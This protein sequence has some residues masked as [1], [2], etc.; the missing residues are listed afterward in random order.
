MNTSRLSFSSPRGSLLIVAM[1]LCGVIGISLVS[2]MHLGRSALTLS[3]RAVYNN[4]AMNLAEQ[5]IEEAMY[6]VNQLVAN[7]AYT[8]PDWTTDATVNK[9]R[10]WTGVT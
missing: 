6:G 9:R 8:W 1:V 2:Y 5:G 4:A 7:P 3:N 10:K